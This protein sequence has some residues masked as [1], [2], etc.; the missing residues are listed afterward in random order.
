MVV[1]A[2][3]TRG[4]AFNGT[5]RIPTDVRRRDALTTVA[6][7]VV[8]GRRAREQVGEIGNFNTGDA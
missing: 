4:G 7:A 8:S 2:L 3:D 6:I 5:N 1:N